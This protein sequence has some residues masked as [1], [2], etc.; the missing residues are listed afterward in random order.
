[1]E[2]CV[3]GYDQAPSSRRTY[4]AI[5]NFHLLESVGSASTSVVTPTSQE[6]VSQ[7]AQMTLWRERGE[8]TAVF[9]TYIGSALA[10][11]SAITM[12]SFFSPTNGPYR[13]VSRIPVLN[14]PPSG[15]Y[16]G[17]AIK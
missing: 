2:M 13:N 12:L 3:H 6:T 17:R 16:I 1:M 4:P 15:N 7:R 8:L 14:S 9:A 5:H 11:S 10:Y